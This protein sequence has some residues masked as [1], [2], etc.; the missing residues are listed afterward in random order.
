MTRR[1]TAVVVLLAMAGGVSC[2]IVETRAADAI[3][4][5]HQLIVNLQRKMYVVGETKGSRD[6]LASAEQQAVADIGRWVERD[7]E[8]LVERNAIGQTPLMTAASLGYAEVVGEL[9]K[10]R[11]VRA[12]IDEADAR[13]ATAWIHVN[14][15]FRQSLW[16]CNPKV[17]ENPFVWVP[18]VVTLPYYLGA[19][20]S[21][22]R[23]ARRSLEEAG[24]SRDPARAKRFWQDVCPQQA[25]ATRAKVEA[26]SDL[27]D[28]VV[29]EGTA[30]LHRLSADLAKGER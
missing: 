20:E 13:G 19:A 8:F 18:L 29:A 3:A 17:L 9:L 27:L 12:A 11:V 6:A 22:Y 2:P 23:K 21:P 1:A 25:D 5:P 15:A 14:L 16:V 10:A 28:T 7:H 30:F 4:K 26:S 24:A